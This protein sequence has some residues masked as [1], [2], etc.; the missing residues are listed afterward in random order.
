VAETLESLKSLFR[1]LEVPIFSDGEN[2]LLYRFAHR[3]QMLLIEIGLMEEGQY[4]RF[5]MPWFLALYSGGN[6]EALMLKILERN[7]TLKLLKFG[8]D[9]ADGEVTLAIEVFIGDTNLTSDQLYRFMYLFTNIAVRERDHL[10][11]MQQTGVYPAS[12]NSDFEE[13][14]RRILDSG[15]EESKEQD[16]SQLDE[17]QLKEVD[18][19]TE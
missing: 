16:E 7:R 9:P 4:L 6:R 19:L 13:A 5:M 17:S 15:S 12:E 14:V 3:N 10:M 18:S 1:T 8:C 2:N 11:T